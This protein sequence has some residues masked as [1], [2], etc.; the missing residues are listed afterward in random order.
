MVLYSSKPIDKNLSNEV[1][2]TFEINQKPK[3]NKIILAKME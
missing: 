1:K 3:N 2:K